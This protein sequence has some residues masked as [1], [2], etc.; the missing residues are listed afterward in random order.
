LPTSPSPT[1]TVTPTNACEALGQTAGASLS[2]VNGAACSS[3]RSAVVQL[4]MRGRSGEGVGSCSG[5]IIAP[6]A[7]LTA[8]HCLDEDAVTVRVWLGSGDQIVAE[9]FAFHPS[10]RPN[11]STALDIGVIRLAEDLPRTPIPLLTSRDARVGET[12]VIAGWGRDESSIPATLRAGSTT[13]S[14][15][16]VLLETQFSTTASSICSGDSGGPLLLSQG[17]TWAIAG[18]SS[19]ASVATC[20]SGTN[21]YVSIRNSTV[22]SYLLDHVPE[23]GQ[24]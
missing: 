20:N 15:V 18:V 23:A 7:I 19:A 21:F 4:N 3:A 16:G 9:S 11:S 12:A 13:I 1:P 10:Y 14:G 2:I 22:M 6:R 17:N 5:T 24:R 8:A